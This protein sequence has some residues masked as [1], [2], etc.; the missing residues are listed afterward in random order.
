MRLLFDDGELMGSY[1]HDPPTPTRSWQP[2]APVR[3]T[4][5]IFVPDVPY[6]GNVP[7]VVGLYSLGSHKRLRLS[8]KDLGGR[9]YTAGMLTF[10]AST[11]LLRLNEGWHQPEHSA[12]LQTE[13]RW[14]G[15]EAS[16]TVQ[17]PHHDSVLYV[18]VDGRRDLFAAPQEVSIVRGDRILQ[19]FVVMSSAPTDYDLPL[20][21]DDLGSD[22]E[23]KLTLKIDKP[24]VPARVRGGG[25]DTRTLGIRVFK[26]FLEPRSTS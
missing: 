16:M 6:T 5:R 24:F 4:R 20:S 19:R 1:D 23:V 11:T 25:S 12:D 2:G 13:W 21:A 10:R 7:I 22:E 18:R 26:A 3:Y 8:G 15:G 17:N 9:T 14:T